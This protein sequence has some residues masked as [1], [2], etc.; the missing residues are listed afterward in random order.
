MVRGEWCAFAA[1]IE[2]GARV[3]PG[4]CL[5]EV[6]GYLRCGL[7][8]FGF[9]RVHC[10][11][12]GKDE[13]VAFSCKGRGFCPSCG[14]R[15]MVDT[16]AW[17]VDRVL[18]EVPVRQWVLSLPYRVRLLC[19]YDPVV[20]AAV[21]KVLVRAVSGYY[22][23]AARGLGKPRPRAGA[24]AFVQ[25][26]D[27]GL[28][29]NVH[30]HVLWLDGAYAWQ[31]G[32]RVQWCGHGGVCDEDVAL[33]VKR[34]RDRVIRKLRKMGKWPDAAGDG[35]G[36]EELT[37]GDE[38]EQLLLELESAAVQGRSMKGERDE[39]AGRGTMSEPFVKGKLCADVDGFSL[40]A[41]VLVP[42][43]DRKRLEKLCRYAG[44]PAVAESRLSLLPDGRVAY[45]LKRKWK[46]GTTHVVMEPG[47][48]I[49]RLVALVPRPRKHLV[50]YHG[51]LAPAA[52]LRSRVVP[53][54]ED[55]VGVGEREGSCRH[56]PG[57]GGGAGPSGAVD[58]ENTATSRLL[59]QRTRRLVPHAS[60]KRSR[61]GGREVRRRYSWAELLQRV[62]DRL[63]NCSWP[64]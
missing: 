28:R 52:G 47:V 19:A 39:R 33:L 46:D 26:F 18:P 50:T 35:G 4:F 54:V 36:V 57:G 43:H 17:L 31:P 55:E 38:G 11:A 41:G 22:E 24:V 53:R 40:H 45:E 34:I 6:E 23:R 49:E 8:A 42:G 27:S 51:V 64:R 48:L 58:I 63:T 1:R 5:R 59:P 16:A 15:R 14:T 2:A 44:R 7:L 32:G 10:G 12:C 61:G 62:F 9:A 13:V 3:V 37:G 25:R 30:F 21:R 60:G 20:C 56:E 29:L